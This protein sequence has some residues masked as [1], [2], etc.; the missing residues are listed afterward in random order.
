MFSPVELL[1]TGV[2]DAPGLEG[3]G[4][5]HQD[6]EL[7]VLLERRLDDALDVG[8]VGD[9]AGDDVG[10]RLP[11]LLGDLLQILHVA[12][13]E[14]QRGAQLGQLDRGCGAYARA[15]TCYQHDF[16]HERHIFADAF[17][18]PLCVIW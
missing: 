9:L 12:A 5:V 2:L 15:G 17:L 8:L 11:A 6:V 3:A 7:A 13:V 4:V 10:L 16:S 14:G 1:E 18:S